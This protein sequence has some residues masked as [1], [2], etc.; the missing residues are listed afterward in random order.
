MNR[1][2]DASEALECVKR[3]RETIC[4]RWESRSEPTL[5]S[6]GDYPVKAPGTG[7]GDPKTADRS[8]TPIGMSDV[9]GS[10]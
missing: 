1:P 3:N 5:E 2:G 10:P 8:L 4:R 9:K 6:C 7:R